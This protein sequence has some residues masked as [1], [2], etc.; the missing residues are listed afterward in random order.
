MLECRSIVKTYSKGSTEEIKVLS[1]LNLKF[2]IW[3]IFVMKYF[4]L[5]FSIDFFKSISLYPLT[6]YTIEVFVSDIGKNANCPNLVKIC[7]AV[8]LLL[9]FLWFITVVYA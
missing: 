5:Y 3:P 1:D 9:I 2:D 4:E 6:E 8:L 7:T